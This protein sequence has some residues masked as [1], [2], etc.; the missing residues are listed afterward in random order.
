MPAPSPRWQ[1]LVSALKDNLARADSGESPVSAPPPTPPPPKREPPPPP[2]PRVEQRKQPVPPPPPPAVPPR[3]MRPGGGAPPTGRTLEVNL[4][5]LGE[6]AERPNRVV[7][8]LL[9]TFV[10]SLLVVGAGYFGFRVYVDGK[11]A[12]QERLQAEITE[13]Q[14]RLEVM[15]AQTETALALKDR[16]GLTGKLL[17]ERNTWTKLF[18]LIEANAVAKVSF[19]SLAADEKGKLTLSG[20]APSYTEVARQ[21][22]AFETAAGVQ[23]VELA[24]LK[25]EKLTP[26]VTAIGFTMT[27]S[28]DPGLFQTDTS[29]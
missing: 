23:S 21:L 10:A 20:L 28:V 26:V 17:D 13:M 11:A 19:K 16:L 29:D 14:Q 3:P 6:R 4:I 15:R 18:A 25:R 1:Q 9:T 12:E 7:G 2:P 5:P 27:V 8:V 22:K 24:G